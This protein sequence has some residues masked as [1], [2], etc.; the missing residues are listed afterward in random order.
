MLVRDDGLCIG[1]ASHAWLSGQLAGAWAEPFA[2]YEEVV[3]AA[4]QHDVGMA[5]W[6]LAPA[7]DPATGLP[8][9]FSKMDRPT[10][11]ALWS[12]AAGK[13]ETQSALAALLVSLHGTGLYERF[14]AAPEHA[15]IVE[16]YMAAERTRQERLRRV[17]G[18]DPD[19]VA[20]ARSLIAA[21][22]AMSLGLCLG[23]DPVPHL[24]PWPF[25]DEAV[26]LRCEGRRIAPCASPGELRE[27]LAAAPVEPVVF[28][29]RR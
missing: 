7:L 20:H 4:E 11:V 13:L 26:E 16:P 17:C 2:P 10:H 5:E 8:L 29:L 25:R 27:A 28:S 22:D 18:A 1:Q 3:L 15:G 9:H 14:P 12:A 21:W 24:D 19:A 23:W 6:D